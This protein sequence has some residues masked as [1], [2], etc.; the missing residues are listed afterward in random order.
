MNYSTSIYLAASVFVCGFC[1][2][3]LLVR[4]KKNTSFVTLVDNKKFEIEPTGIEGTLFEYMCFGIFLLAIVGYML[5]IIRAE[6]GLLNTSWSGAREIESGYVSLSGLATR[7]IFMLSGLSLFYFLTKRRIKAVVVLL[8][9]IALI[10]VTR[11]RVQV[12]PVLIFFVSLYLLKIRTIK[13]KHIVI[14]LLLAVMVI[15]IIYAIRAF[16][17]LGTLSNATANFSWNY[18]NATVRGFLN[19][20]NGELGLR[21][22]FYFFIQNNNNFEGF[23]KGYTYIRMLLVYI[24]RQWSLGIKP[25]SF[26]LL[27]GKA[28]GMIA[29]G[30]THPTIFA[31]CFGNMSW[32]GILLGGFWAALSNGIDALITRQKDNFYKIMLFFLAAY[33][34]V[35]IGRGSVY[36]GFEEFAWGVLFLFILKLGAPQLSR[37]RFTLNKS[38]KMNV[39]APQYMQRNR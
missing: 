10:L 9:F 5:Y 11:N 37:V 8:L 7:L 19:D 31:D 36:N 24:P 38:R 12:L 22:Y 34:F 16:R 4:T 26:D 25:E 17:Y 23:N 14:G 18:I 3:Y 20:R 39:V 1:G 13:I 28:I 2:I 29:G 27:M 35:V 6:G 30:T 21:Q 32:F 33:S 15:Y